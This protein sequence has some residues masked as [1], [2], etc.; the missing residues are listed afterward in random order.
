MMRLSRA[1]WV[2]LGVFSLL[3]VAACVP[4]MGTLG[5]EYDEAH[6]L[7]SATRIAAG[8]PQKLKPPDGI[9]IGGRPFPFMTMAYVGGLDGWLMAIP[10][11]L[12]GFH[13]LVPRWT[14][15]L[16]GIVLLGLTYWTARRFGSAAAGVIAVLM[17]VVDFEFLLHTPVH[18]GPFLFQ[19]LFG[20]L[21]VVSLDRW[22]EDG[23]RPRHFYLACLF[24]G[25]AF[26][27]KLTF[28]WI[29]ALITIAFLAFRGRDVVR[30][31]DVRQF[32]W[33]LAI[34]LAAALPVI[35]YALGRPEV[36]FGFGRSSA[37]R[38]T[39]ETLLQRL[40]GFHDLLT[41]QV[42]AQI[43]LA[44][45]PAVGRFSALAVLTGAGVVIAAGERHRRALLL[46]SIVIGLVL[47]NCLFAEGGRLHYYLLAYPL[48]QIATGCAYARRRWL[49]GVAVILLAA[50]GISTARNLVWYTAAVERTGGRNHWSSAIYD[51]AAWMRT[52]PDAQYVS[53]AWGFYRPLY[54]LTEGRT[55]I[56]DRY[57]DLLP[58]PPS[59]DAIEEM[60]Y[61]TLRRETYWI[62]SNVQPQYE[63]NFKKL[64]AI[65]TTSFLQPELVKTFRGRSGEPQYEVYRFR[66]SDVKPWRAVEGEW[67]SG[68]G[69]Q[70][71][72]PAGTQDVRFQ[73]KARKW[74]RA[75]AMTVELI[76]E[77]GER[78]S[79]WWRPLDHY[80]LIWPDERLMFGLDL[81][82]DYFVPLPK[83]KPGEARRL[84]VTLETTG[85][86]PDVSLHELQVR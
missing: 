75:R 42:F 54:F 64:S 57:F 60:R 55:P 58:S 77:K 41:G 63:T 3:M 2:F 47:M 18:F 28:V 32:G 24:A 17:L 76:D 62:T 69:V 46:Y 51:L 11:R 79:A 78:L 26:N 22:L 84:H 61:L 16:T 71:P 33:G 74:G 86:P 7:D 6:F 21:V 67:R 70:V 65:A 80:P 56:R 83:P 36:V 81:F 68:E 44:E 4:W 48:L 31:L 23:G 49:T 5:L 66:D 1:E 19:C 72:L 52:Q 9:S 14:N 43:Q 27:E 8:H 53:T 45:T 40:T 15:L 37:M 25:L 35:W 34:F 38:P 82:P 20:T 73:L 10:I 85:K 39:W 50:T 13:V 30:K 12:F 29:L 59:P